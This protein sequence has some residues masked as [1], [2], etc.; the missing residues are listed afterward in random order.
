[1]L[2]VAMCSAA[3]QGQQIS[4]THDTFLI[5]AE[6]AGEADDWVAAIRRVMHE[7]CQWLLLPGAMLMRSCDVQPYGGGMFGRSLE[8]TMAVETRLGGGYIPILLHRCI[9]FL[10]QHGTL[11]PLVFIAVFN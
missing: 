2:H 3:G 5:S 1:M 8:E 10:R 6:S 7:V 4:S 9:T 11:P